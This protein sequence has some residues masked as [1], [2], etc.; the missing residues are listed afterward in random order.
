MSATT[1]SDTTTTTTTTVNEEEEEEDH[2]ALLA[3]QRA[4]NARAAKEHVFNQA[5]EVWTN[6]Q[7]QQRL[8][9]SKQ[10]RLQQQ[11]EAERETVLLLEQQLRDVTERGMVEGVD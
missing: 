3:Y 8:R 1:S 5:M 11:L 7:Q 2:A 9:R 4:Y 6:L 10:V